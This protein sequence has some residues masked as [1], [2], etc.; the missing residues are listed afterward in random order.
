MRGGFTNANRVRGGN[1]NGNG[2]NGNKRTTSITAT[3]KNNN[4][5]GTSIGITINIDAKVN[6]AVTNDVTGHNWI[7]KALLN[8][9]LISTE[10][11]NTICDYVLARKSDSNISVTTKRRIVTCLCAYARWFNQQYYKTP[12]VLFKD[13]ERDAIK[14]YLDSM[15]KS[16]DV[17]PKQCWIGS[18]NLVV[19]TLQTFYKWLYY[20]DTPREERPLPD[21]VSGFKEI[22]RKGGDMARYSPSDLWTPEEHLLFLKYCPSAREKAYHAMALDTSARPHELLKLK[23][24]D[25]KERPLPAIKDKI[26]GKIV[27]PESITFQFTVSGKT[28]SR[29]LAL[30][31]SFPYVKEW[32]E[33]HHP[34]ARNKDAFLFVGMS[35]KS[36][37]EAIKP[38]ALTMIYTSHYRREFFPKLLE[39]PNVPAE[40]KEVIK[41]MLNERKWNPYVIRHSALTIKSKQKLM[42]D[43]MLRQHAGWSKSSKM[44][45]IYL[46]QYG[47]ESVDE[48]LI[49]QGY[50][51]RDDTNVFNFN[52][53]GIKKCGNCGTNNLPEAISC[54]NCKMLVDHIAL[55]EIMKEQQEKDAKIAALESKVDE[56]QRGLIERKIFLEENIRNP[57]EMMKLMVKE[58]LTR[59]RTDEEWQQYKKLDMEN[60]ELD[61]WCDK[62]A[63]VV[64]KHMQNMNTKEEGKEALK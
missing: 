3:T 6:L 42:N 17:D 31:S 4:N 58:T 2:G 44:P 49:S 30:M 12:K 35:D 7:K 22:K 25:L 37:G 64:L 38:N 26:T 54:V 62:Q 34:N 11:A 39:N 1:G 18:R 27:K 40:D 36:H 21:Q 50:L 63:D 48:L 59:P 46:H 60:P 32:L 61:D 53:F 20:P 56:I 19:Q 29:N 51:A 24:K 28:G 47:S 23:I 8:K 5:N 10:N 57:K 13:V 45:S 41:T 33:H 55:N 15:Q 43:Q 9:A 14:F 52:P 16:E